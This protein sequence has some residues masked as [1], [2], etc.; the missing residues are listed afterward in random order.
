MKIRTEHL[1]IRCAQ[2]DI[3]PRGIQACDFCSKPGFRLPSDIMLGAFNWHR[4]EANTI[5]TIFG[6][7]SNGSH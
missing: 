5:E 1:I 6:E 4:A 3:D 2:L 7:L